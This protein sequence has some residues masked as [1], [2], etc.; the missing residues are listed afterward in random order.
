M[1]N[2]IQVGKIKQTIM[3]VKSIDSAKKM[4]LNVKRSGKF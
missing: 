4:E 2:L 1:T 3:L